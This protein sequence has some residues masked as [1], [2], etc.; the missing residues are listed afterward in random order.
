MLQKSSNKR[1]YQ[2]L[3]YVFTSK[4]SRFFIALNNPS[5]Y[6]AMRLMIIA[7]Q[8]LYIIRINL[9]GEW[10]LTGITGNGKSTELWL[11]HRNCKQTKPWKLSYVIELIHEK[12]RSCTHRNWEPTHEVFCFFLSNLS[13]MHEC[14]N[15]KAVSQHWQH[16]CTT[17][18]WR[19]KNL[20]QNCE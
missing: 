19:K 16:L 17:L 3:H 15:A 20:G 13:L 18:G 7:F 9:N 14:T 11:T 10:W 6:F 2:Q 12:W 1:Q 8:Y 5:W 4:C